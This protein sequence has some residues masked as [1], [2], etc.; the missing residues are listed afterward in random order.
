MA[1]FDL[2]VEKGMIR[3]GSPPAPRGL[4]KGKTK[5]AG[6]GSK[7]SAPE[8]EPEPEPT[9]QRT[10][11]E[12][13]RPAVRPVQSRPDVVRSSL[14]PGLRGGPLGPP[15]PAL[16]Q[17]WPTSVTTGTLP[18][19]RLTRSRSLRRTG[20]CGQAAEVRLARAAGPPPA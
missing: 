4:A 16:G 18:G 2:L 15:A 12:I 10:T 11:R 14:Q 17:R 13:A 9:P 19:S 5:P 20:R 1:D 8:P 6:N 7:A 3:V